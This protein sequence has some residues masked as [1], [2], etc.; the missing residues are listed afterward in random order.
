MR[1][2]FICLLFLPLT[3]STVR[4]FGVLDQNVRLDCDATDEVKHCVWTHGGD[5]LE[6]VLGTQNISETHWN[7]EL[8]PNDCG[9]TLK[10]VDFHAEGKWQCNRVNRFGVTHDPFDYF[11]HVITP[12]TVQLKFSE[13]KEEEVRYWQCDVYVVKKWVFLVVSGWI[14]V[15]RFLRYQSGFET[16]H[17]CQRNIGDQF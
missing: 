15:P 9:L 16:F 17:H 4:I 14:Q 13:D 8:D 3:Q 1:S 7:L 11:V 2:I 5:T 6:Y 10:N 12:P